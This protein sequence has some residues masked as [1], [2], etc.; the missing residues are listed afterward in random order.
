MY[1]YQDA[2]KENMHKPTWNF[3][4]ILIT[5]TIFCYFTLYRAS[6]KMMVVYS[7]LESKFSVAY[8]VLIYQGCLALFFVYMTLHNDYINLSMM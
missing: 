3:V 7:V 5:G 8:Y 6:N 4:K 1:S 2:T